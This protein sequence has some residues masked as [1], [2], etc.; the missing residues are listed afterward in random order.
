MATPIR[1]TKTQERVY[2]QAIKDSILSPLQESLIAKLSAV[3]ALNEF[4]QKTIADTFTDP[5]YQEHVEQSSDVLAN[6]HTEQLDQW[7]EKKIKTQF[8]Q[9]F[10]IDVLPL[11]NN[12]AT[13]SLLEP[14]VTENIALIRSIPTELNAQVDEAYQ[15]I[16]FEKGFDQ[17]AIL[18]MLTQRFSVAHS[19]AQLI[20]TDQTNKTIGAL[21][22]IRQTQAGVT[23]F[24]WRSSEDESVRPEHQLLN[25]QTFRW[26]NPPV[27]GYPGQPIRC[28]CTA[29]PVILEM[30]A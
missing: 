6:T 17:P 18:D 13:K 21:Q 8:D 1:P 24:V 3:P 10:N 11:L 19:R 28:R 7:H 30:A 9:L 16:L 22:N 2:N 25:G 29:E 14:V 26:D 27:V 23:H 5:Q 15:K 4:W 12:D 20:A